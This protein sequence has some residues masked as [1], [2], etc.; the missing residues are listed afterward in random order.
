[1]EATLIASKSWHKTCSRGISIPVSSSN[2]GLLCPS[3]ALSCP[4]WASKIPARSLPSF[5]LPSTIRLLLHSLA[6]LFRN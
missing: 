6:Y 5:P 1:M 4:P 3:D 2:R